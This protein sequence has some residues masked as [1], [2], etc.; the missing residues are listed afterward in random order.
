LNSATGVDARRAVWQTPF[1]IALLVRLAYVLFYPQLSVHGDAAQ[2]DTLGWSL[3]RGLGYR[4][5]GGEPN[6][7]WAPGYPGVLAVVYRVAGHSYLAVRIVQAVLGAVVAALAAS[8]AGRLFDRRIATLA[9]ILCACYP[10]LIG[11]SGLL[12]TEAVFTTLLIVMV[13]WLLTISGASSWR[14]LAGLGVLGGL[15]A[16][17]RA[18]TVLLPLFV[19]VTLRVF[20]KDRSVTVKQAVLVYATV[21]LTLAPWAMRNY[22]VTGEFI[23][24]TVHG[25]DVLWI[26]SYKEEWLEFYPDK[27]PYKS[28][29]AGL[30][31]LETS[32]VLRREGI[33]N[34]V[35]D[36]AGFAWLCVKRFPRL[37]IGGHSNLFA[38]FGD[39][40]RAYLERREYT[41]FL[42][43]L[44]LLIG[45]TL[46]VLLG[47]YGAYWS[48]SRHAA[49]LR[50]LVILSAP[51]VFIT[52]I[53][54]VLFATPRFHVPVM[55][56]MLVFAAVAIHRRGDGAAGT[57]KP[58]RRR[59]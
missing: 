50:S 44:T 15:T 4:L 26:S 56:F 49:D 43:K 21:A 29:V 27:E 36:P 34:I 31:E 40:T 57:P 17:V 14:S 52:A 3:A 46:L 37:W 45:N 19:F 55:P 24:L 35:E 42:V 39:S 38:G 28:L 20:F 54:V 10:G 5:P 11:Y 59:P 33:R 53:H 8:I 9:G 25:G 12:L 1:L 6:V 32:K 47:A 22:A 41:V 23:P 51:V 58:G 18:E 7:Y 2:Y 48:F 16:L 13:S 30:S